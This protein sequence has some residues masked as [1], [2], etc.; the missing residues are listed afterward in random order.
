MIEQIE[1]EQIAEIELLEEK[2]APESQA[3]FLD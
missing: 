2:L 1:L 3:G